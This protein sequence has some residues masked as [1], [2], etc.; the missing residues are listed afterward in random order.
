[1][2]N[3]HKRVKKKIERQF[4]IH[5]KTSN[6]KAICSNGI[7]MHGRLTEKIISYISCFS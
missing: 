2:P 4:I 5:T 1:M 3:V 6:F 7:K